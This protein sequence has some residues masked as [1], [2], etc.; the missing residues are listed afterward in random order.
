[1]LAAPFWT[2]LRALVTTRVVVD[3]DPA[4]EEDLVVLISLVP[5]MLA[6]RFMEEDMMKVLASGWF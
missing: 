3:R 4:G 5:L 2:V 1:M 6:V